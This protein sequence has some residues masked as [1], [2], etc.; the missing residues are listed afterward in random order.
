[1]SER[2]PSRGAVGWITFAGIMMVIAGGFSILQGIG[3]L[4]N[5]DNFPDESLFNQ[6]ATTWGW[7]QLVVGAVVLLA[8]FAVFSGNV[9]AR[10]VGVFLAALNAFGAFASLGIAPVW[11]ICVIAID[12]AVIW[13]LTAHGRDVELARD[14]R[15]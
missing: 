3:W 14:M 4:I 11:G 5:A 9:L 1:V 2:E 10:T 12:V 13:A 8:G 7:V 6:N 15:M